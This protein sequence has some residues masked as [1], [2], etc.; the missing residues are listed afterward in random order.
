MG[1]PSA[2]VPS[3]VSLIPS[4]VASNFSV[5]A[6]IPPEPS[7]DLAAFSF[8]VPTQLS[9]AK[10]DWPPNNAATP[11]KTDDTTSFFF[12]SHLL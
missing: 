4:G 2:S 3:E 1:F 12:T 11:S 8:Q 5:W 6:R 10:A 7:F 9:P